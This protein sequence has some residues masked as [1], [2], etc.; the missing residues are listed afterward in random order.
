MQQTYM[1]VY[2]GLSKRLGVIVVRA[3]SRNRE[4]SFDAT[5]QTTSLGMYRQAGGVNENA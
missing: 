1:A 3:E 2:P 4:F 5:C